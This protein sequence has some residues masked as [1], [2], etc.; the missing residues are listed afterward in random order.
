MKIKEVLERDCCQTRDL[1]PVEGSPLWG[2]QPT[3]QFCVHCGRRHRLE[4]FMD[5]A[6]SRDWEYRLLKDDWEQKK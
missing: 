5:P 6:G 2:R 3:H 1:R 4:T